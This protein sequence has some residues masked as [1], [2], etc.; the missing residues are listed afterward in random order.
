MA[1]DDRNVVWEAVKRLPIDLRTVVGMRYALDLRE[2]EIAEAT[3]I[4]PGTVK[5]RLHR[6]R[7]MFRD[8]IQ[9]MEGEG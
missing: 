8:Y 1:A 3:G 9:S 6:A 4:P 2:Q 5:S 7:E